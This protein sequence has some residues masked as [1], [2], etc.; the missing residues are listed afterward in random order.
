MIDKDITAINVDDY[1]RE[2]KKA[3]AKY[4]KWGINGVK[5]FRFFA[6]IIYHDSLLRFP[7]SF[8]NGHQ[9]MGIKHYRI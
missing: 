5:H 6:R 9:F 4:I 7:H 1:I 8:P 2:R 3:G